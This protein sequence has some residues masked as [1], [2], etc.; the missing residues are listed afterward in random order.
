MADEQIAPTVTLLTAAEHYGRFAIP[1]LE[2]GYGV[3]LGN[4]LRRVLL[5]SIPVRP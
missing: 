1:P 2:D 3:T 4:A 5:S